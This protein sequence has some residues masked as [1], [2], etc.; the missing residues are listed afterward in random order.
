[1]ALDELE[2][3]RRRIEACPEKQ[4]LGEHEDRDDERH[5]PHERFAPLTITDEDETHTAENVIAGLFGD[6][7]LSRWATPLSGSEDF[8]RVL[9]EVPGTFIGL[10]IVYAWGVRTGVQAEHI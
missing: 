10:A 7:R 8:S 2:V 1:M 3:G 5:I 6:S 4:R 9:A